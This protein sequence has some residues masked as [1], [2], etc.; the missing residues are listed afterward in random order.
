MYKT[1]YIIHVYKINNPKTL[2]THASNSNPNSIVYT[3]FIVNTSSN[4]KLEKVI[5]KLFLTILFF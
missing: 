4:R 2:N 1:L 3:L 5:I